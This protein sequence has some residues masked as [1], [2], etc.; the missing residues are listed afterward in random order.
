MHFVYIDDSKDN[1]F[2]CFSA[3][4]IPADRWRECLDHLLAV[5]ALMNK[6]D[7]IYIRKEIHATDWNGGKGKIAPHLINKQRRAQLFDFFLTGVAMMPGAQVINGAAALHNEDRTFERLLNRINVN[8]T[9]AGSEALIFCDEGKSFDAML[10]RMRRFNYIPSKHGGWS[11]GKQAKNITLDRILEDIVY[12][13]SAK[14]MMIQA[15]DCCG[16][17]LL[18]HESPVPSK[19]ALGLHRSFRILDP[20][21]V[22]AANGKDALGIIR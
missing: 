12:R 14:S 8:M 6:S 9:R 19:T 7:G 13:N 21:M 2:A 15:A 3:L 5:R 16:Y 10:R 17:A 18:R 20:I 4:L 11:G 1:N 22:L